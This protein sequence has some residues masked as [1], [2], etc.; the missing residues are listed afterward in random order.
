MTAKKSSRKK[1]QED[2]YSFDAPTLGPADYAFVRYDS[3]TVNEVNREMFLHCD[4]RSADAS[5]D[6][7]TRARIREFARK[8]VAN[9]SYARGLT[10]IYSGDMIGRGP[11]LQIDDDL[12]YN[13]IVEEA[14]NEWADEIRLGEK[15]QTGLVAK[16]VDGETFGIFFRDSRLKSAC[17]F[18]F[19]FIE[20]DRVTA[21]YLDASETSEVDGIELDEYGEPINY[22]VLKNHP[23]SRY[24][25]GS[26]FECVKIPADSIVHWFR[27]DRNEQHR[28]VSEFA[29]ALPLFFMLRRY[30]LA[31]VEAA[32]TA[33]NFPLVLY[34]DSPAIAAVRANKKPFASFPLAKG[35]MT[36]LP[37][38][39]EMGQVH[40]EQPV[41]TY[42]SFKR[43]LL[44]EV[45]RCFSVPINVISGDSSQHNYASGRLDFQ[46][47]HKTLDVER[48][49]CE[50]QVLQKLFERWFEETYIR[51]LPPSYWIARDVPKISWFW[52]GF[53]HVDPLKEA[54][55]QAVRLRN[56]TTTYADECA[57]SG[58]DWI[59]RFKQIAREQKMMKEL[60][61]EPIQASSSGAK[62]K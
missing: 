33:A 27:R 46:T 10:L 16:M 31:A 21:P 55:A 45:A 51:N 56:Y 43:E 29:P 18:N 7:A 19:T 32:E 49:R 40:A 3:A 48:K 6:P 1:N 58:K 12:G 61:I 14:F 28:G 36:T 47:Y 24:N 20:C 59:L 25:Y 60:G 54:N 42:A 44:A 50:S 17:K 34:T 35:K 41:S 8:E 13:E 62:K 53:P 2:D 38:G 52:D 5:A 15:L 9:N 11:R 57:R 37:E 4:G 26:P 23:G 22:S 39:W 30:T